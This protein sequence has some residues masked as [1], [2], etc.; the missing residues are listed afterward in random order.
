[1]VACVAV[2]GWVLVT[3][4]AALAAGHP[5]L[6]LL[7]GAVVLVGGL[8]AVRPVRRPVLRA[9]GALGVAM[10]LGIV[11]WLRPYPADAT[12]PPSPSFGVV[13]TT[14]T[15]ELRPVAVAGAGVV[16]VPGALVDPRAYLPILAPLAARGHLV[17]VT[18]HP[19][20]ISLLAPGA[21]AAAFDAHP[22]ID[23]WV[24]AGYSLGGVSASS[25]VG[26]PRVAG[27]MLWASY[28]LDDL[29]GSALPV[30]SVSGDRDGLTTPADV[31]ASRDKLP[32][33]AEFVVVP[34]GVHAF[35]GDYGPQAGDGTP[36]TSREEAQRLIV[37]ASIRFVDGL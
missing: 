21:A 20:G 3:R 29:S 17:V 6:P 30:L 18:T 9:F 28:P 19:L 24:V 26:A 16:F 35:F 2:V 32:A 5:A 33:G 11:V 13:A 34:G 14:T 12:V 1:M 4:W 23:R 7:L 31:E 10:L 22:E 8:S 37:E 15:W 27:L 25:S 36:A